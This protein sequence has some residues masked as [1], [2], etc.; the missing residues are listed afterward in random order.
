MIHHSKEDM[1]SNAITVDQLIHRLQSMDPDAKVFFTTNY[2]DY[3]NTQ[4]LIPVDDFV[5][6]NAHAI[7]KSAYSN[8]GFSF[9][10]NEA[11]ANVEGYCDECDE[12]YDSLEHCPKCKTAL[13]DR[14]GDSLVG[15]IASDDEVTILVFE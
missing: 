9:C 11:A 10:E 7:S 6:S 8:S 5:E 3:C 12:I 4:Q 13:V 15:R 14:D 2:G 1:L